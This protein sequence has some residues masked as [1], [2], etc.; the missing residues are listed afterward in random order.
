MPEI[1][2]QLFVA[3]MATLLL[4]PQGHA[5]GRE[6]IRTLGKDTLGET[7]KEF[8]VHYPKA[9]CGRATSIEIIPQNLVNSGN[10][11]EV[12][13]CLNDR[14]SLTEISRFPILNFDD[15]AVHAVFW[16]SRLCN[17]T[18]LLD[19]R[20]VQTVPYS[21]EKLYGPPTQTSRDPEDA[22]KLT[23][24]DWMEGSTNL[25]LILSRL[26]GG[27]HHKDSTRPKGEPWLETVCVSLWNA[28]LAT[29]R[30]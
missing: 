25:E 20:S 10:M 3:A 21:F 16:K 11:D 14:D 23:F 7:V 19:V 2:V 17:L 22:S 27:D 9:T 4:L 5:S 24:V 29:S 12:H 18:Y 6:R 30:R 8:R 28:D 1:T 13:C 26:D 15:C